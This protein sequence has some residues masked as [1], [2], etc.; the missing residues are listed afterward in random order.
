MSDR[1]RYF[2][3]GGDGVRYDAGTR[4]TA[5]KWAKG[6]QKLHPEFSGESLARACRLRGFVAD[7]ID[8]DATVDESRVFRMVDA[9]RKSVGCG[10]PDLVVDKI[11]LGSDGDG[12]SAPWLR[13]R[14]EYAK[15]A[16]ADDRAERDAIERAIARDALTLWLSTEGCAYLAGRGNERRVVALKAS[17]RWRESKYHGKPVVVDPSG[18]VYFGTPSEVRESRLSPWVRRSLAQS[19]NVFR[20]VYRENRESLKSV[21]AERRRGA[22]SMHGLGGENTMFEIPGALAVQFEA[23]ARVH[24]ETVK[25]WIERWFEAC[26]EAEMDFA[27]SETGKRELP[28]TRNERAFFDRVRGS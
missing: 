20:Y 19:I 16:A 14:E 17:G 24:G 4:P 3:D 13:I 1:E 15:G 25:E 8:R 27:F 5:E 23:A 10:I 7:E 12:C 11:C 22:I 9:V 21:V 28:L 6:F 26:L 18:R 2:I